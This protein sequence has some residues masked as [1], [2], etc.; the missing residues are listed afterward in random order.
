MVPTEAAIAYHPGQFAFLKFPD[1]KGLNNPHP[2]TL[3]SNPDNYEIS[4]TVKAA[5][6][7]T[8]TMQSDLRVG[9]TALVE[10]GYGCF[11]YTRGE[12]DQVWIAGGIGITPFVSW[13]NSLDS[14]LLDSVDLFYSTKGREGYVHGEFLERV[15]TQ[16][17]FLRIHTR[18]TCMDERITIPEIFKRTNSPY[19]CSYFICGPQKMVE[20]LYYQL[21]KEGIQERKIHY[22]FFNF[23]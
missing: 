19:N 4:V 7:F 3:T 6:D 11:D 23:R 1:I 20:D 15:E 21:R 22:E 17:P 14:S 10:G 5:G 12:R 8:R 18:D 16:H 9:T 2:F 13:L